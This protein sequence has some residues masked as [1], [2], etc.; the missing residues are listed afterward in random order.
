MLRCAKLA[1]L[2][3]I[4]IVTSHFGIL[5]FRKGN[6][7]VSKEG[8]IQ[9]FNSKLVRLKVLIMH[10]HQQRPKMFQFQTGSIKSETQKS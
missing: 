1:H 9:G 2:R 10:Q 3:A 4:Q 7:N 5:S 8:D 6:V